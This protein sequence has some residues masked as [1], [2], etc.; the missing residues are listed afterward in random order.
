MN[1]FAS[2]EQCGHD[3]KQQI[4]EAIANVVPDSIEVHR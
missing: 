4:K 3:V 2:E 1:P